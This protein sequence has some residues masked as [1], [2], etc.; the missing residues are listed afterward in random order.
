[1]FPFT[2]LKWAEMRPLVLDLIARMT[3]GHAHGRFTL[4]V[5]DFVNT[6]SPDASEAELA[7]TRTRGAI[8]FVADTTTGGTFRLARAR[9]HFLNSGAKASCY[10]YRSA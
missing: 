4:P 2:R 5:V 10:A 8:E 3:D 1:M 9:P 6:F 7:K